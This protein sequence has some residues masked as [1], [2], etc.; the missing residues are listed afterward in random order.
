MSGK[1]TER[2]GVF[3]G[4]FDPVHM[5]HLTVA[6][7]AVEQV[8]LDRLVFVPAAIS[9]HKQETTPTEGIHR[10]EML[11]LATEGN[12]TFEVSDMEILR[13]GV[14]YTVDTIAHVQQEHPE[15][16]LFFIVGLDSLRKMHRWLHVERIFEMCTVIPLARGG[17][18]P[19]AVAEQSGL[20]EGRKKQLLDRLIR[21]H[22]VE[23]SSSEVRMR[24]AEGLSV[25]YL[26]PPAV[27]MYIAEHNLY[28]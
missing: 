18:H 15:A 19:E 21:I 11:R 6:Q 20:S 1:T 8:E 27:E 13:G 12:L 10:L 24:V 2:I 7:D 17:E 23:V 22:E 9:P 26:V 3:G 28:S 25:H 4:S 5:G 16:E 14:S